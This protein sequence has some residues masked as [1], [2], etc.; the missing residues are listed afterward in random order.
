MSTTNSIDQSNGVKSSGKNIITSRLQ[1]IQQVDTEIELL[2]EKQQDL[3]DKLFD[4]IVEELRNTPVSKI[5]YVASKIYWL[6]SRMALIVKNAYRI[7][8]KQEFTPD[9]ETLNTSCIN[10]DE[11][12]MRSF[13][14]WSEAKGKQWWKCNNCKIEEQNKSKEYE[15][16]R[17]LQREEFH[18]ENQERLN[19]IGFLKTLPYQ[20]YLQ[21]DHWKNTRKAAMQRAG[22]KCQLCNS[23]DKLQTHHRT[24]ERK[25]CEIPSDLIVLCNKC[26][27]KFHDILP[28]NYE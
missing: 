6:E 5:Q 15:E 12:F 7:A 11:S 17:R 19:G 25:G 27:E 18:K 14:S 8:A 28:D 10:C 23:T 21:T 4:E 1:Q 26:H 24:Y 13:R 3:K 2:K 20:E 9:Y 16:I 22:F